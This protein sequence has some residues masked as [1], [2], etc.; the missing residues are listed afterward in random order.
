MKIKNFFFEKKYDLGGDCFFCDLGGI[1]P[2]SRKCPESAESLK[3][4]ESIE[5]PQMSRIHRVLEALL[6]GSLK[7]PQCAI[8]EA[9]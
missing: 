1:P 2:E 4:P 9:C 3:C 5:M 6:G 8:L 7:A